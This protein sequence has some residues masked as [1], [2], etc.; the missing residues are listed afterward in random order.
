MT[1]EKI[2]EYTELLER[3]IKESEALPFSATG[4]ILSLRVTTELLEL[5]KSIRYSN[6]YENP[7]CDLSMLDKTT[8]SRLTKIQLS[9]V[10][11]DIIGSNEYEH[12]S[13]AIEES[14]HTILNYFETIGVIKLT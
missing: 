10:T 13:S 2:K 4:I 8:I 5:L 11:A 7:T 1:P 9:E 14:R 3:Y 12:I 6:I